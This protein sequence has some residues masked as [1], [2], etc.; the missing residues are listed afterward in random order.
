MNL[1]LWKEDLN[2]ALIASYGERKGKALYQKYHHSFEPIYID[3]C[4][5][6]VAIKDLFWVEKISPECF[7]QLDFYPSVTKEQ[8]EQRKNHLHLRLYKWETTIPLSDILP[9]L[10]DFDFRVWSERTY[11][12]TVDKNKI[13]VSDFLVSCDLPA[14]VALENLRMLLCDAF[15]QLC[16]GNFESDGF[17]KLI[18]RAQLSW[19]E[20]TIL[21]AYAKYLRQV[22]FRFSQFYIE[23]A[24]AR[25]ALLVKDLIL[26]FHT[27][28]NP[29]R[30]L[31]LTLKAD[32]VENKIIAALD[33]VTSLDEDL[34]IR[35]ML[36][37]V[38]ATLRTNYYQSQENGQPKPYLA[39]KLLS[40]AIP[41]LPLP[42]PRYEIFSYSPRFE[43]IHLRSAKV[44][45]GGIRWSDRREDFRR[46]ILGLMKAQKVK[47]AII[48][49]SG[50]KGGFV[51]KAL[52]N[53]ASRE[54]I[55]QEVVA[56][57]QLFIRSLLDLTDN[58]SGN[59]II[60]PNNVVCHDE[61]DTYLVVAA[62]KGTATFSDIA[63]GVAKEYKFWLGDAFAS[64]GATGY[65]HKKMGIT[66]R[67]AWESVKR[68]FCE[69]GINIE[70]SVLTV[71]GIGDMS[72]DVFGN[73]LIYSKNMKLVAAFDH[74]HIFL[75]PDPDP[76]LSYHERLRLFKLFG[77]SWE[78]YNPTLISKGGGVYR[79]SAKLI[80]LSPEIKKVLGI[81]EDN[82]IPNELVRAVLKAPVDLL[83]NGGIGTYVKASTE[84][85]ADVGDKANDWNR[86]NG[87]E[88]RCK[89]VG[90]GGNLGFTQQGRVEYALN[91]GLINTDFIDNSAGVDCSD[92]EVNLKILLNIEVAKGKLT[93]KKRNQLL[94]EVSKEVA[95]LVLEDNYS[96]ACIL[97]YLASY[98]YHDTPLYQNYIKD[99]ES[100][101]VLDRQVEYLPDDKTIM[102]RRTANRGLVRPELAILLAYTKI[103]LKNE[104]L[105]S[106]VPEDSYFAQMIKAA[107]PGTVNKI[108]YKLAQEHRLHR[109][110]IATQL[111]SRIVNEMGITFV[112]RLQNEIGATVA[113]IIRAH[114]VVAAIFEVRKTQIIIESLDFKVPVVTQHELLFHLQH[115]LYIASRW[116]LRENRLHGNI[117]K[118]IE[119]YAT[120]I[121]ML[122]KL[123][124]ELMTG[125]TKMYWEQLVMQFSAIGLD[126]NLAGQIAS[127]RVVYTAL[128]II[129]VATKHN[130]DVIKTAKMYFTV[131]EQFNLV[132]F[133]D[134]ISNDVRE[135]SWS[136]LARLTLRDELDSLQKVLTV[137]MMK[138]AKKE[139]GKGQP[140]A[141]WKSKNIHAMSRW[142]KLFG[143]LRESSSIDYSM[144]FI[145]LRELGNLIEQ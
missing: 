61:P 89:V 60:S 5:I 48:V 9:I 27:R 86:I 51:L 57:Y 130:F 100:M 99:L 78:N 28:N 131:G 52:P 143:A 19:R 91:Q 54:A 128:N 30:K 79:R 132:W 17:N 47:N 39:F 116:F 56:C 87:N 16:L 34:I 8:D 122:E 90:E 53:E 84:S 12:L 13:W 121:K 80:A 81:K 2:K 98:S 41:E 103:H 118:L 21:R 106:N 11:C 22:E 113:D 135:G 117:T 129:E 94:A 38:K 10:G 83:W 67:G 68:H 77:S 40:A 26:L 70:K 55:Q 59:K 7:L 111:S 112:P 109:E 50:A 102:D 1:S 62:D 25:H 104:I 120:R 115:L 123:I 88:L 92:H 107:F 76:T 141:Q 36:F 97:N 64:G 75:D 69:L 93:E 49:P 74:R 45:R 105:K 95:A 133:R 101:G 6:N 127:Y 139:E 137:V 114:S 71:V 66:A 145:V 58:I 63:N 24:L 46:E 82:L 108:Y 43:G 33:Q 125:A 134:Y 20:V 42:L 32:A 31:S 136:M 126:T 72:G 3:E 124:L 85:H 140:I 23:Q 119:H 73:G 15:M 138:T 110:I 142:E 35:R 144:F 96:Q 44:A 65:D 29:Q 18:I 14:Q 37:L 4:V